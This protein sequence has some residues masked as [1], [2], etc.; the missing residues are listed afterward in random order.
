MAAFLAAEHQPQAHQEAPGGTQVA[1]SPEALREEVLRLREENAQ[2]A[3]AGVDVERFKRLSVQQEKSIKAL[4][5]RKQETEAERD[6][7]LR[8]AAAARTRMREEIARMREEIAQMA[9]RADA[10]QAERDGA[11]R[12]C[13]SRPRQGEA[14]RRRARPAPETRSRA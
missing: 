7:A 4:Q 8:E 10:L 14:S 9:A 1:D 11:A 2:M 3:A 13:S 6:V 5:A 12:C